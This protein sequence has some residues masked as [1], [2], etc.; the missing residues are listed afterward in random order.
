MPPDRHY[1]KRTIDVGDALVFDDGRIALHYLGRRGQAYA[2]EL[3]EGS[4]AVS[5]SL[6]QYERLTLDGGRIVVEPTPRSGRHAR[7][8]VSMDPAIT[9]NRPGQ[10]DE[11]AR[12]DDV[13][14]PFGGYV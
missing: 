5:R 7:L 4:G 10:P 2:F 3:R 9:I 6:Y 14:P 13:P 8:F 12:S 11:A 1:L